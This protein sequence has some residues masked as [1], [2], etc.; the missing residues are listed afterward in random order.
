MKRYELQTTT[1]A[2][3]FLLGPESVQKPNMHEN[4]GII[5]RKLFPHPFHKMIAIEKRLPRK[6]HTSSPPEK[7][8]RIKS[9]IIPR[10]AFV[11]SVRFVGRGSQ[12]NLS[13]FFRK[14]NVAHCLVEREFAC[15]GVLTMAR[16]KC[17]HSFA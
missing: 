10:N 12:S 8:C 14:D 3:T 17:F 9:E 5:Q 11:F 16:Y 6:N 13:A 15:R 1:K 7:R 4:C 2:I